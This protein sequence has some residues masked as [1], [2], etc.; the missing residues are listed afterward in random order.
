MKVSEKSEKPYGTDGLNS[1]YMD[2]KGEPSRFWA[3]ERIRKVQD[4]CNKANLPEK[5]RTGFTAAVQQMDGDAVYRFLDFVQRMRSEEI[6]S[7][8]EVLERFADKDT[9][10]AVSRERWLQFAK[11][12]PLLP[13]TT[14]L[15]ALLKKPYETEHFV[16]WTATALL[17]PIGIWAMFFSNK[18]AMPF[19]REMVDDYFTG[20]GNPDS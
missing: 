11:W 1:K 14:S 17:L 9:A 12:F 15:G 6:T 16:F 18:P 7:V 8:R 2:D 3:D 13:L 19:T 4:A 10:R 5:V 20:C